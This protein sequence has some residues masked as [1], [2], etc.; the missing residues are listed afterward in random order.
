MNAKQVKKIRKQLKNEGTYDIHNEDKIE[1][2]L[3]KEIVSKDLLGNVKIQKRHTRVN[4]SKTV[5]SQ[6]KRQFK[7]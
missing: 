1:S 7:E 3:S 5:Y 6:T 4:N 2:V